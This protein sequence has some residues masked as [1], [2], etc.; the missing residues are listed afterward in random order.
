MSTTSKSPRKVAAVA[1]EIGQRSLPVYAS[2]FSRRDFTQPQLFACLVLRRFHKTDYR[3]IVAILEDNPTLCEDLELRKVPHFTTLQ[4]AERKLLDDHN[5]HA[6]LTQSVAL[7]FDLDA[8]DALAWAQPIE[9]VA[10]DSTGFDLDHASRYFTRRS[11]KPRKGKVETRQFPATYRAFAKL[12]IIACC[13]T[14]MVLSMHRGTGPRPDVDELRPL[15]EHF[16]PNAVPE[17]LLADAG[18]DSE[19]NHELLRDEMKIDSLIPAKIGRPTSKLP[20]GG[21]RFQMQTN[22]DDETYGQR[23]QVETVMFM[24]KRHQGEA[25]PARKPGTRHRELGLTVLTHNI[26]IVR[27]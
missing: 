8:D 10:A 7:Y 15:I 19:M 27:V 12:G 1:Y 9:Q 2:R 3:G 16:V 11:Q 21:Y 13:A 4:K 17:Q 26:M 25:L 14:H 22:F 24:F 20:T 23:W 6:M 18:Y 5:A